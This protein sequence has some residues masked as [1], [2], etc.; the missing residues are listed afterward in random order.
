M[1]ATPEPDLLAELLLTTAGLLVVALVAVLVPAGAVGVTNGMVV[2]PKVTGVVG[3]GAG[4]VVTE[5]VTTGML[6]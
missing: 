2:A 3:E 6:M 5:V 1:A 4:T